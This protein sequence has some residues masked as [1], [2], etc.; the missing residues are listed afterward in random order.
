MY[1]LLEIAHSRHCSVLHLEG[2][3]GSVNILTPAVTCDPKYCFEKILRQAIITSSC[4]DKRAIIT[5]FGRIHACRLAFLWLLA[6]KRLG[7]LDGC[8]SWNFHARTCLGFFEVNRSASLHGDNKHQGLI[9]KHMYAGW[10]ECYL[11]GISPFSG[12][13]MYLMLTVVE[14]I[15]NSAEH[16][17]NW[18]VLPPG[19][20]FN[21][22][23][24][25]RSHSQGLHTT[26]SKLC[27]NFV[28]RAIILR[29]PRLMPQPN[30]R[31]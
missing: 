5:S 9:A 20:I 16:Q 26:N 8:N 31:A 19:Y 2:R 1:V 28:C 14:H 12:Y 30:P 13:D 22:K 4:S 17:W 23:Y 25:L 24:V 27:H 10:S 7:L 21:R 6:P 29:L 15:T 11:T 18:K 3:R